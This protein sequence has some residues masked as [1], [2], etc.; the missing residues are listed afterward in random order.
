MVC[1][2]R[3]HARAEEKLLWKEKRVAGRHYNRLKR[4]L[5]S[6]SVLKNQHFLHFFTFTNM[7]A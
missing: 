3:Y 6:G 1:F 2:S 5:T 4:A 7:Q